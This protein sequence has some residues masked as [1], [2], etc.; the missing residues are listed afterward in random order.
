MDCGVD[1]EINDVEA[2][3][4][5]LNSKLKDMGIKIHVSFDFVIMMNMLISEILSRRASDNGRSRDI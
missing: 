1:M 4:S 3:R 2:I 5:E